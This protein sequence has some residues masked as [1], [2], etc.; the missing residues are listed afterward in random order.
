MIVFDVD[1][2]GG[3]RLKKLFG[4]KALS[5][6]IKVPSIDVLRERLLARK[7]DSMEEIQQRLDKAAYEMQFAEKFDAIVVNDDLSR[8][9]EETEHLLSEFLK[10]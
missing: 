8:A 5:L 2:A 3:M 1:V 7:T 10:R 6:F 9:C 4:D